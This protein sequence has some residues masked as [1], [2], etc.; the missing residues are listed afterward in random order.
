MKYFFAQ[1][2][3]D[4]HLVKSLIVHTQCK[5]KAFSASIPEC[6]S[7]GCPFV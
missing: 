6:I 3:F 2:F 5:P 7:L 1:C 4:P